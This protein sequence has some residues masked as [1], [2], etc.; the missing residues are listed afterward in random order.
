MQLL[1]KN[2]PF[3]VFFGTQ[4]LGS[5]NDNFFRTTFVTLVTFHFVEYSQNTQALFVSAA[6]AL[7]M[8][9]AFIFSPLAGQ[10]SDRYD[11]STVIRWIKFSEVLIVGVS[12]Y[13]FLYK[14]PYFLLTTLFFMGAHAA[15]F[16]PVKYSILPDI[17]PKNEILNG[18]GY[19]EAGTFLAIMLGTFCGAFIVHLKV[20]PLYL[21]FQMLAVALL[22]LWFSW[23]IPS[24]PAKSPRLKIR[25][26]WFEEMKILSKYVRQDK[27]V[28][29]SI[30]SISWFWLIGTILLSQLPPFVK[31]VFK[32]EELIFIFLLILFT[33]GIG[34]G[35]MICNTLLKGEITTRTI[36]L[37]SFLMTPF[38][39]DISC[40]GQPL[41]TPDLLSFLMSLKG[42]RFTIDVLLL[43]FLGGLFIVPLYAYIQTHVPSSQRS[44]VIAYNN[45]INAGFMV[46]ASSATF[47]LL[48]VGI[49]IPM[50]IL[51]TTIGHF[52]ISFYMIRIL[53][54]SSLQF[55]IFKLLRLFFRFEVKGLENYKKAGKRVVII[56]NHISYLDGLLIAVALPEKTVFAVN[57]FTAQKWWVKPFLALVKV[58]PIDPLYPYAL[59]EVIHE[60]KNGEKVLIFPEGRLTLTGSLMKIYEGPGLIAEKAK[61]KLLPIRI[62]GSQY[63]YFSL[64][65]G[66]VPQRLFPKITVTILP[67]QSL[68]VDGSLM[69]RARR[70]AIS[71]KL[72]DLMANMLFSTSPRNK[73]LFSALI[74]ASKL[75]GSNTPILDDFS[76]KVLTYRKILLKAL[77]LSRVFSRNTKLQEHVGLLLPNTHAFTISF[78]ALQAINRIPAL[79]NY[80]A[81]PSALLAACHAAKIST[82]YTSK[83]FV[84]KA[85]LDEVIDHLKANN[86][87]V[88]YLENEAKHITFADKLWGIYGM[89]FPNKVYQSQQTPHDPCVVL[90]TS[91]SEGL[92]KGVVLSHSNLLS[93]L[94]Q[95]HTVVDFNCQDRVLNV[96]PL[97]HGFGLTAGMLLPLLFGVYTFQY[98]SPLHY[99]VV[100]ELVYDINATILFGTDTFLKGYGRVAHVYDFHSLRYI[101]AGAEKLKEE[102]QEIWFD[103]FGLRIFEGYGATEAGPV[104]AVNTPMHHKKGTVGRFLPGIDF[105][106]EPVEG[107]E[108]GGR[109]WVHGPNVMLGYLFADNPG[110]LNP[111]EKSWYDTGDIAQVD[112]EQYLRLLGRAKRFAKVG[113]EMVS[114][115]AVEDAISKLWPEY[116]NGVI[117]VP[118]PR[119]GEQL[120]LFTNYSDSERSEIIAFW[121]KQGLSE[122]SI[123]SQICSIE[124]LPLLGSGKIDYRALEREWNSK[125]T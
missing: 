124:K 108:E 59:R 71:E 47:L 63:S 118:H 42:V 91:G 113:G 26:S 84:E 25:L 67:P 125:L 13:G 31:D 39:F 14:N 48:S 123:P 66:R 9:P 111:P 10:V 16:G 64:L 72:Y 55:V 30:I 83:Q 57:K 92:P 80:T 28:F 76:R 120:V 29:R 109:L 98:V 79:L 74:D 44:Q 100:A 50:L 36:P 35:S 40:H 81:G 68:N 117:A 34:A 45:I 54:D 93:N 32:G 114:L 27:R 121:K 82:I 53:P 65:K 62:E 49:S 88:S 60:A 5:F 51:I 90:F 12:A 116:L 37:L 77:T 2:M 56:A 24:L 22:G 122:I 78:W 52:V 18:N 20:P 119:K 85:K 21:S 115:I 46:F 17:L 89:L 19:I 75:Y 103:K 105:R 102:T 106:L 101:F 11:K 87:H 69:G 38:L 61:A 86:I 41:S 33:I 15:F 97:F 3:R 58:F 73:T 94:Y 8:L 7:F 110:K 99:K 104:L 70:R 1:S 95:L 96:L 6:F 112:T 4:F 43:S 107:I 23:Q